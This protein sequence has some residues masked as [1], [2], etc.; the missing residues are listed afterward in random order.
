MEAAKTFGKTSN[1]I[2]LEKKNRY[3]VNVE[4]CLSPSP[5]VYAENVVKLDVLRR[6]AC[7]ILL[8]KVFLPKNGETL[9]V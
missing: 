2:G 9:P 5:S 6:S 3:I 4:L 7:R 1:E 8:L